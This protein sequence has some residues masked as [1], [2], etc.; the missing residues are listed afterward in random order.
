MIK[1][2]IN[3]LAKGIVLASS[4]V[5]GEADHIVFTEVVLTPSNG[6]YV[7]I[8][9]PTSS[10]IDLSDYYLTDGTDI[11]PAK[12]YYNLP[13]GLNYWSGSGTDFICRFPNNYSL[14]AGTSIKISLRDSDSYQGIYGESADLYLDND[15]LDA[16]EGS[17]TIGAAPTGK[18]ENDYESLILFYWDGSSAVVKDIDYLLWGDN[19][20]AIDKSD[21]NGYEPDTP[22]GSQS[23]MSSHVTEEKLIRLGNSEEGSENQSGGNGLTGHDETSEPLSETW[24]VVSLT[25][26][27]PDI[28]GLSL[29]PS[30]PTIESMLTFSATVT[31]DEGLA[32]VFLKYEFQNEIVS[33][34]MA[35]ADGLSI[36]SVQVEPLG[37]SGSLIYSVIA[38]DNTGLKDST[39][40]VAVMISEP[41]E[42]LTIASLLEDL[43]SYIG[44]VVEIDGVVTVPAG[45]LRTNFTEAFLQDES[46]KGI[47]L[48][49]SQLDTSFT[50]GDS[51]KVVAEVDDFDGKPELI[52]SSITVLKD[53]VDVPVEEITIA[54]FNS[55]QYSYTFVKLWGKIISRSDPFGTNTGANISLQDAS[56][57]VTTVRI[58]NSTNILYDDGNILINSDLDSLLQIGNLIEIAGIGGEYSGA[59]QLQPAYKSDINEKLEGQVGDYTANLSVSPYPFVPQLGEVID[60]SYSFPSDARIKLRVFDTSGRL[61]TTLY[62]EYR[63][64]SFYNEASWNGRDNLNRLVPSG[65]YIIH[66]DVVDALTGK[67]FQKMA[68]VVIATYKN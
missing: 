66:L 65:T 10:A 29:T 42:E 13:S 4:F 30:S 40:K 6:E 67:S 48:Y 15:M 9:N 19:S 57:E 27:K 59:S 5:F 8:T 34:P 45:R 11:G 58:W 54:E 62:D 60:Y 2:K 33:L 23:F 56:G 25:S 16:V 49:N 21:V 35:N 26:S 36:Y 7:E 32:S 52:Y 12:F 51:V 24:T 38:E 22:A 39:S 31:D 1:K 68:P 44:Q 28:S 53:S 20:F 61:I 41:P 64:I 46:G 47:I 63:G 14:P 37:E 3:T 50:R 18:L 17:S 55:L 43:D